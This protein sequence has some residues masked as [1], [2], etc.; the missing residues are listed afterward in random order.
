MGIKRVLIKMGE[1]NEMH[2]I[3]YSTLQASA[4]T[5]HFRQVPVTFSL[6]DPHTCAVSVPPLYM[7]AGDCTARVGTSVVL[8]YRG[9]ECEVR[10]GRRITITEQ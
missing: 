9:R 6:S 2:F 3:P 4:V 10:L 1:M 8:E 5:V 7:L